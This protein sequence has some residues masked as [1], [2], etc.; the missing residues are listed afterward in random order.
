M[1]NNFWTIDVRHNVSTWRRLTYS[2]RKRW[3]VTIL[4][5]NLCS[6]VRYS[7]DQIRISVNFSY[8]CKIRLD[9][10][11]NH[12]YF[13]NIIFYYYLSASC[14][15]FFIYCCI[16]YTRLVGLLWFITFT[17]GN[18]Q[19][20]WYKYFE[21]LNLRLPPI[22]NEMFELLSWRV[23]PIGSKVLELLKLK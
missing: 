2:C 21:L 3:L 13:Y 4:K 14:F 16:L 20:C 11:L 10:N 12:M 15:W 17:L 8:E 9:K 22:G 19:S 1:C 6:F 23:L 7:R 5:L 18:L